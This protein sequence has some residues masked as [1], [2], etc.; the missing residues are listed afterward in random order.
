[1]QRQCVFGKVDSNMD[2]C[3]KLVLQKLVFVSSQIA[4]HRNLKK[5]SVMLIKAVMMMRKELM[6]CS[7]DS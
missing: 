6:R 1:M 3:H 5:T 4:M 7:I 2:K